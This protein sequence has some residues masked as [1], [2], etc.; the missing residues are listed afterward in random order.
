MWPN[1]KQYM[2]WRWGQGCI[3]KAKVKHKQFLCIRGRP[4]VPSAKYISDFL[5]VASAVFI[6]P[7]LKCWQKFPAIDSSWAEWQPWTSCSKICG[8]GVREIINSV[9]GS[10]ALKR[11]KYNIKLSKYVKNC[12][13]KGGQDSVTLLSMAEIPEHA[14]NLDSKIVNALWTVSRSRRYGLF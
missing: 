2:F 4:I 13:S 5:G 11:F 8:V 9:Y 14:G 3:E 12:R 1:Y 6:V 7:K 10:Q